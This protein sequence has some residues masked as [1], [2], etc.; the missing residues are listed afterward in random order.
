MHVSQGRREQTESNTGLDYTVSQMNPKQE[1][2]GDGR[3]IHWAQGPPAREW[4]DIETHSSIDGALSQ[5]QPG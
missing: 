3:A 5:I 1:K 4:L 2:D